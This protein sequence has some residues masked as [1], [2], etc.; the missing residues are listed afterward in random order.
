MRVIRKMPGE[1]YEMIEIANELSALQKEVGGFIECVP[2]TRHSCIICNEEGLLYGLPYNVNIEGNVYV[3][4]ILIV[5]VDGEDFTD[6][7]LPEGFF[8]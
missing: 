6:V 3:G 2:L 8:A 5:G 4:T 1:N 7:P